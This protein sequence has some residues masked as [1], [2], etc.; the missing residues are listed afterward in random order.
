M[1]QG[2][3]IYASQQSGIPCLSNWKIKIWLQ[4]ISDNYTS[5]LILQNVLNNV[6]IKIR[7]PTFM[8]HLIF[9]IGS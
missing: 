8:L 6:G 2:C 1:I 7:L 4:I 3:C 5:E 9:Y